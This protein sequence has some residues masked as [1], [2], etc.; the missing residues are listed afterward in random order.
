MIAN[1]NPAAQKEGLEKAGDL[2]KLT[3]TLSTGALVFGVGLTKEQP[4]FSGLTKWAILIG[5]I[6]LG[7]AAASGIIAISAIPV[8]M[9]KSD[10]DLE[11]KFL[12]WPARVHQVSFVFGIVSLGI[13]LAALLLSPQRPQMNDPPASVYYII[14]SHDSAGSVSPVH[15][16][17]YCCR[18]SC[19]CV[20]RA[21]RKAQPTGRADGNRTS[22]RPRRSP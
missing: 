13:A 4:G 12:T 10:Y 20:S 18:S 19:Q 14:N 7:L 22:V 5:W 15:A 1:P 2:L 17:G 11:N 21:G 6:L 9:A 3:L 16:I 8:M